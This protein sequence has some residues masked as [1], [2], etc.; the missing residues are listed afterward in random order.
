VGAVED[1]VAWHLDFPRGLAVQGTSSWLEPVKEHRLVVVGDRAM[2]VW[3]DSPGR[4]GV[5][6]Y[7]LE[8]GAGDPPRVAHAGPAAGEPVP[9]E[10]GP[11]LEL[12][13]RAFGAACRGAPLPTDAA[14]GVAVLEVMDA[15]MESLRTGEVVTL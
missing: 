11:P 2:A 12:E 4:R 5:T 1:T 13:L 6:L 7:P 8:T 3:D 10:D 14:Q 9:V 15:L